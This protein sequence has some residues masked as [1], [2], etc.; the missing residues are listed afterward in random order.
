[1]PSSSRQARWQNIA[2]Q[3]HRSERSPGSA[4]APSGAA[5]LFW[6][7]A[8]WAAPS[9]VHAWV[10]GRQ[11]GVSRAPFTSFNLAT[12][13]GDDPDAV[14]ANRRVLL[15]QL[16]GV[17]RLQWLDQVHGTQ[18]IEVRPGIEPLQTETG[19]AAVVVAPGDAAVIL[20]ADCLPVFFT[21]EKGSVAAVAH[22]GWRGLLD[23]VLEATVRVMCGAAN[24]SP[25][26]PGERQVRV[27]AQLMAW[28]GPAIGPCHF[29][30]GDDVRD[31]FLLQT[32][33][34]TEEV[35]AA[36]KPVPERAGKW[37]MDLYALARLRL[38]QAGVL[39]VSGGGLCTVCQSTHCYSFRRDGVTG[40][41]A[42]LIYLE[43]THE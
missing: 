30:V 35:G 13:V 19:D 1:M 15:Q 27:P 18:V 28:L 14:A 16:P 24:S 4:L 32:E 23:G 7:A 8:E 42:S 36:F 34:G 9:H 10:T 31:A 12:H 17:R 6:L 37:M 38:S 21:D 41:H 2:P 3:T 40:R 26:T 29:E 11:G 33:S 39:N 22:A 25:L 43:A 20:T 5:N